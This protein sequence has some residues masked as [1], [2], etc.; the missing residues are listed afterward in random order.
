MKILKICLSTL[1]IFG[2]GCHQD[3]PDLGKTNDEQ[4]SENTQLPAQ[5]EHWKKQQDPKL[6]N[7][8]QAYVSKSL[9]H[10]VTLL[11]LTYTAHRM[12]MQCET[13]RFSLPPQ[14]YWPNIIASIQLVERMKAEGIFANY[15]II[16]TYRNDQSNEC[17]R[18]AKNSKH[19]INNAVDFKMLNSQLQPYSEVEYKQI[20]EKI[21]QFW[22]ASGEALKMGLGIYPKHNIHIDTSGFRA[23]GQ[24]YGRNSV[25]CET[26]WFKPA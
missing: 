11:D 8:Y 20:E 14:Q 15:K 21:C 7:D 18:G 25:P 10:S 2:V 19:K 16:S 13:L 23:W 12:P 4:S 5:F 17:V 22:K 26:I 6:L 24:D 1:V 3:Q 9:Q